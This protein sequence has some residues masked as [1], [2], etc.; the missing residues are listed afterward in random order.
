M[1]PED[2]LARVQMNENHV[3]TCINLNCFLDG[4]LIIDR[5]GHGTMLYMW[6]HEATRL[7][8]VSFSW[9]L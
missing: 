8:S 4:I 9:T 2:L 3:N 1:F 7:E 6:Q 5:R